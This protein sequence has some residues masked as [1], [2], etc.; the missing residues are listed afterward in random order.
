MSRL[1]DITHVDVVGDHRLRLTF[2]DGT[3]GEV[4]FA[5]SHWRGVLAPLADPSYFARVA[6]DPESATISWPNGADIAPEPLSVEARRS[7]VTR[8]APAAR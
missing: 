7:V 1:F 2:S 8:R 3:V 5:R 4:S 6:V